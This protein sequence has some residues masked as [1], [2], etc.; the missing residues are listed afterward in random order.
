MQEINDR[1]FSDRIRGREAESAEAKRNDSELHRRVH[2]A[3]QLLEQMSGFLPEHGRHE[4]QVVPRRLLR[5]R[6]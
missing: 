4:L 6:R 3:M 5:V 1:F 2:G